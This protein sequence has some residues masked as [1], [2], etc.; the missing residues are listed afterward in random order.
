MT[1]L[2]QTCTDMVTSQDQLQRLHHF[3]RARR[4]GRFKTLPGMVEG[5]HHARVIHESELARCAH[6]LA[7][8][9]PAAN[10]EPV[11]GEA[12]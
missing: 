8:G 3:E 12:A 7:A 5:I 11:P 4:A 9:F 1:L 6:I 2:Q 10:D